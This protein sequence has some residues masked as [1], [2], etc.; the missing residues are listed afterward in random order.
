MRLNQY[1][2]KAGITSR[3]KADLLIGE[4]RVKVNGEKVESLGFIVDQRKDS[5]EVDGKK[6]KIGQDLVYILLNKPKG[7]LCTVFD[8]FGRPTVLDLIPH[9]K[10]RVFPVGRLDLDSQ[11]ALLL[12]NNGDLTYKLTHPKF[13]IEKVYQV[14]VKGIVSQEDVKKLKGG[15]VLEEGVKANAYATILNSGNDTTELE[16]TL[17][18]GRKREIRRIFLVLGY[19][20]LELVR[21][22]FDILTLDGLGVGKWR[23]LSTSEVGS[24]GK[25]GKK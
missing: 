4:G 19:K 1:L 5:V 3:R 7:Y 10:E 16:V 18:E 25:S 24:L 13:Q 20:V 15:I 6:V 8:P 14:K 23:H 17:K 22:R 12:T 2:A 11:G 9:L 21:K